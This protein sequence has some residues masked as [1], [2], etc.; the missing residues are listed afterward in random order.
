MA[1]SYITAPQEVGITEANSVFDALDEALSILFNGQSPLLYLPHTGASSWSEAGLAGVLAVFGTQASRKIFSAT[2]SHDQAAFDSAVAAATVTGQ[3]DTL[4]QVTLDLTAADTGT[5]LVAHQRDATPPV[6]PDEPYWA[7]VEIATGYYAHEHYHELA[8]VDVVFEGHSSRT[9]TWLEEWNKFRCIRFHN[10]DPDATPLVVTMEE[11]ADTFS[12]GP[13]DCITVRRNEAGTAWEEHGFV[14]WR[15]EDRDLIRFGGTLPWNDRRQAT[16][17]ATYASVWVA[18]GANNVAS[19]AL[20]HWLVDYFALPITPP[21]VTDAC[22]DG[23]ADAFDNRT[24]FL[25]DL[26][27]ITRNSYL[28]PDWPDPTDT[29]TPIYQLAWHG[30]RM[31]VVTTNL[32]TTEV[33]VTGSPTIASLLAGDAATGLT[34]DVD[35]GGNAAHLLL[36]DETGKDYADVIPIGTNLGA[37]GHPFTVPADGVGYNVPAATT[38]IW[39]GIKRWANDTTVTESVLGIGTT[40]ATDYVPLEAENASTGSVEFPPFEATIGDVQSWAFADTTK[41]NDHGTFAGNSVKWDGRWLAVNA[42]L[43]VNPADGRY[44]AGPVAEA[45][46]GVAGT[47]Q[48][49]TL[50]EYTKLNWFQA[51][52]I[53]EWPPAP[54]GGAWLTPAYARRSKPP[55]DPAFEVAHPHVTGYLGSVDGSDWTAADTRTLTRT[56]DV[57]RQLLMN[58]NSGASNVVSPALSTCYFEAKDSTVTIAANVA[59]AGWWATNR[60]TAISGASIGAEVRPVIAAPIMAR[61][62]NAL[63]QRLNA[64][65]VVGPFSFFDAQWYGRPFRPDYSSGGIFGGH[66]YPSGFV[67]YSTGTA[68]TRAADLSVT[69]RDFQ[70]VYAAYTGYAAM[71]VIGVYASGGTGVAFDG[72]GATPHNAWNK[73]LVYWFDPAAAPA[74]NENT[75]I[76]SASPGSGWVMAELAYTV[77]GTDYYWWQYDNDSQWDLPDFEYLRADDLAT[78]A[79]GLGIPFRLLRLTA[80][81]ELYENTPDRVGL[82]S[83]VCP[84][85]GGGSATRT[86]IRLIPANFDDAFV[87]FAGTDELW[88]PN[89]LVRVSDWT[90]C[91]ATQGSDEALIQQSNADPMHGLNRS[92][93]GDVIRYPFGFSPSTGTPSP[94]WLNGGPFYE[95][96]HLTVEEYDTTPT[97]PA[98]WGSGDHRVAAYPVPITQWGASEIESHAAPAC[99]AR[100]IRTS[101]LPSRF[102]AAELWSECG[103]SGAW[104]GEGAFAVHL[105]P[106]GVTKT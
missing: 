106:A 68:A 51:S 48:E 101:D 70:T 37:S 21:V 31:I 16:S 63:A 7:R 104:S 57:R 61:H 5:S 1:I 80:T 36:S 23:V 64:L 89:G 40:E 93:S 10:L 83:R 27:D 99:P 29:A 58:G 84:V 86:E 46:A 82:G 52:T 38:G 26:S 75:A 53:Q 67:C 62:Y 65:K 15:M 98:G 30:G 18:D 91:P 78:A 90:A 45:M 35:L 28:L 12:L 66:V 19:W 71:T 50:A 96:L 76:D 32:D 73:D 6:G 56:G 81:W 87:T 43:E 72:T 88:A 44:P 103:G 4:K 102:D 3:D 33:Q 100:N 42:E 9:F 79:A 97:P 69:V 20:V 49:S 105:L 47:Q 39:S 8:V 85:V 77:T 22:G 24:G 60:A 17:G 94:S 55:I 41:N 14:L 92:G 54:Y 25:F 34:L 95:A 2:A 11:T 13:W 74:K 59:T